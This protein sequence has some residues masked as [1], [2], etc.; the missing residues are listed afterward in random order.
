MTF[1]QPSA[2]PNPVP[3]V[4]LSPAEERQWAMASHFS[5][6]VNLITGFLGVAI[7]LVIYLAYRERSRYVAYHSLQ[8][9]IFQAVCW[10]GGAALAAVTGLLSSSIPMIGLVCLPLACIFGILPLVALIYGTIGGI[11]TNQGQDF[12]YWLVGDWVRS[13]L[14]G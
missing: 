14:T 9:F 5:V 2:S 6:L 10:F 11:Q 7:P 3:P 8:A 1:E 4:P 12:K 13:T